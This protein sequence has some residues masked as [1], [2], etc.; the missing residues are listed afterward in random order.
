ML[1]NVGLLVVGFKGHV[2]FSACHTVT[3][4][5]N[6]QSDYFK[7]FPE[8]CRQRYVKKIKNKW[9]GSLSHWTFQIVVRA[10]T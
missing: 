5:T 9:P 1:H 7:T 3:E 2:I 10:N 4:I 8:N 6:V